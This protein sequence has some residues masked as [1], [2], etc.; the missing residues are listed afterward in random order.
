MNAE[1]VKWESTP[2]NS[3]T[4]E[5]PPNS[6]GVRGKFKYCT[7]GA[8]GTTPEYH[9]NWCNGYL[10]EQRRDEYTVKWRWDASETQLT[11]MGRI[12]NVLN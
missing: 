6:T 1:F 9:S 10:E 8:D 4:N 2:Q 11:R 5:P 3:G 12:A 7:I